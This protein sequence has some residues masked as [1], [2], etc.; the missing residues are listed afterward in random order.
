MD[1]QPNILLLFPD[2]HRGDWIPGKEDIPVKMPNLA[3]LMKQGVHFTRAVT[4]S[5]LCAPARACLAA[6][7]DYF[8][9]QVPN[10]GFNYLLSKPT[11]YQKLREAGYQVGG[12]GKFDLHKPTLYW[13][14]DGWIDDLG[15]LGFTTAV[16]NAGKIDAVVSAKEG[17][18]DPY[19]TCLQKEGWMEYHIDDLLNRKLKTHPT[20]LP[21]ELYC[22][23]WLTKNGIDLPKQFDKERPWFLQVNFTGPHPPFD[24]TKEMKE[25]WETVR[26][27]EPIC[28]TEDPEEAQAIRQNYAAM[29][30]NIDQRIGDILSYL[31]E[32]GQR[33]HTLIV[34]ASDHGEM[35]GDFDR[36]GKGR[37]EIPSIHI[38]FIIAGP[39]VE[40]GIVSEALVELQDLAA[41]FCDYAGVADAEFEDSISLREVLCDSSKKGKRKIQKSAL[42]KTKDKTDRTALESGWICIQDE[43]YKLVEWNKEEYRYYY[44]QD[45]QVILTGEEMEKA[46]QALQ[47]LFISQYGQREC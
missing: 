9:C 28:S 41:T 24:V 10:N 35:L 16:D 42:F 2:E 4:P 19:M 17:P 30:E 22:D 1:R 40:K 43:T 15:T 11:F 37:P 8:S 12:V 26:F 23:N 32:T 3:N 5:P 46:K 33:D 44:R 21:D 13:G 18:K 25:R 39:G 14:A 38:P 29:L 34:Y 20:K 27:P 6:G 36:H 45:D 31:E 7:C 47:P